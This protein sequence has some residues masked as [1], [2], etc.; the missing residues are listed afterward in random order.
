MSSEKTRK[1]VTLAAVAFLGLSTILP[2][3][4]R[5]QNC[6]MGREGSAATDARIHN[7]TY[8]IPCSFFGMH[9]NKLTT[10][11]PVP[12]FANL[13]LHDS[14]VNWLQIETSQGNYNYDYVDQ[15]IAKAQAY[16]V[17]LLYTF[18]GVP[19]FYS[20]VPGD[21]NCAYAPGACHPPV[22][23]N[24]DGSGTDAA[25]QNFVMNLVNHV[26]KNIQYW[27]IW[28][29]PNLPN[30]WVPTCVYRKNCYNKTSKC[31]GISGTNLCYAQL[32]RMAADASAIIKAAN[33]NAVVL[34]PAPAGWVAEICCPSTTIGHAAMWMNQYLEWL[35]RGGGDCPPTGQCPQPDVISFHGYVNLV[36]GGNFV[37]GGFPV[38]EDEPALIE[39][40]KGVASANGQQGKPLWITEGSWDSPVSDGFS[41]AVLQTAFLARYILLQQSMGI[42]QAYWYQWD[43]HVG[44]GTLW[45][46]PASPVA[47]D[48]RLA[49]YAY[50]SIVNWTM[51]ATLTSACATEKGSTSV[52]VCKYSRSTPAD[53]SAE[54][55][56]NADGNSSYQL[57]QG[58]AQYCDLK[59]NVTPVEGKKVQIGIWPI[60]LENENLGQKACQQ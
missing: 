27:E 28:S 51:G 47:N 5:A 34:T 14:Y 9:I 52:W 26:G 3:V 45:Q 57:T 38:A 13:R 20:S 16:N 33:P 21:T 23:L 35:N 12:H 31:T 29:E 11:W 36:V 60:L 22:D 39:Q 1:G 25:F 49:G 41:D 4:V 24:P 7:G 19:S 48:W 42:A 32:L 15:W 50:N 53:Y 37:M 58:F 8:V 55:V 59:G 43:S 44:I 40:I 17:S 56:W 2:T 6:Q 18:D 30:F 10:P 46:G 54:I